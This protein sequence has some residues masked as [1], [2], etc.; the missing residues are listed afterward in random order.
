LPLGKIQCSRYVK[1]LF[2]LRAGL[3]LIFNLRSYVY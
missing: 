1:F 3:D 2:Y